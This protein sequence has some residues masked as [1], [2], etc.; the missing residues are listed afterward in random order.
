MTTHTVRL[1]LGDQLNVRHSWFR[2]KEQGILY[3]MMELKQETDY[4]VH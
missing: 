2:Q 3:V 1:I 4:V